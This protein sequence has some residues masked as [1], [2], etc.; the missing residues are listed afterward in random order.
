[1]LKEGRREGEEGREG[2]MVD[3]EEREGGW[4]VGSEGRMEERI[5]TRSKEDIRK[6]EGEC[7][8]KKRERGNMEETWEEEK[9]RNK[10]QGKRWANRLADGQVDRQNERKQS[11]SF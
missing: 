4:E 11:Q 7:Q 10:E 8:G 2:G 5:R 6:G 3:K 1:M 9:W